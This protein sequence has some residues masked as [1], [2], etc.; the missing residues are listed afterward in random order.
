MEVLKFSDA[1]FVINSGRDYGQTVLI[2]K[3]AAKR[4]TDTE[5]STRSIGLLQNRNEFVT[6]L[7]GQKY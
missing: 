4:Q 2:T 7:R 3:L 5:S 1:S 6:L